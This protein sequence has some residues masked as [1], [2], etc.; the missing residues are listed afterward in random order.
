LKIIKKIIWEH[1]YCFPDS[2]FI[3]NLV[4]IRGE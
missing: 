1:L 2:N 4:G 3:D